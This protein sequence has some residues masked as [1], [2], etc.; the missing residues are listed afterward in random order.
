[1]VPAQATGAAFQTLAG[2]RLLLDGDA[3]YKLSDEIIREMKSLSPAADTNGYCAS[4][5][6][7]FTGP[8]RGALY[9][10]QS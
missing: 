10:P 8:L 3:D 5:V 9:P 4:F 6:Y 1:M 2:A 7:R